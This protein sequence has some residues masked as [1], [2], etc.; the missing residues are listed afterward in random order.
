M[1]IDV[2]YIIINLVGIAC[3]MAC[4]ESQVPENISLRSLV[5]KYNNM[6]LT[7]FPDT[8][9]FYLNDTTFSSIK[10]LNSFNDHGSDYL[11]VY[12][13]RSESVNI[14]DLASKKL[15]KK[16][17][18]LKYLP[19]KRLYKTT[20]YC[21]NFDSIFISNNEKKLYLLDS[22][23]QIMD[24]VKF[25][26]KNF[27][28]VA[29][30]ENSNPVV[31]KENLVMAGI[32]PSATI[33]SKRKVREWRIIYQ[34]DLLQN[35]KARIYKLPVRY[36]NNVYD[37]H[38]LDY[39]YCF[40]KNNRFIFSFPADSNLYE[41]DLLNLHIAHFAK[42]QWQQGDITPI[43]K[44][45]DGTSSDSKLYLKKDYYG[46]VFFDPYHKRYLRFFKRKISDREYAVEETDRKSTVLIFNDNLQII[47]EANW[48][49]GVSFSS[50]FFTKDG[51]MYA[52]VNRED[53]NALHFI[54][55]I[56]KENKAAPSELVKQDSRLMN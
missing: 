20:V 30:L 7:T 27:K 5:P 9:H 50:L 3:V 46:A 56:Y 28:I 42:S 19:D 1:K 16:I 15:I 34:F 8:L 4:Q 48:P 23:G 39:S 41:T 21:R 40:N 18:P 14:F 22:S 32:R 17:L 51:S 31:L 29:R 33:N 26:D 24:A 52:R 6:G 45:D 53:E 37:Y 44:S 36:L 13:E 54:R 49:D 38:F 11:S 2:K 43:L 25:S 35:K 12:D 10:S 47:G 55:L